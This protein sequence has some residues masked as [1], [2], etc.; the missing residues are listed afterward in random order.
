MHEGIA[1]SCEGAR[2]QTEDS[3]LYKSVG[4]AIEDIAVASRVHALALQRGVG[5]MSRLAGG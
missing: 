3:T 4:I 2:R 5:V 1:K